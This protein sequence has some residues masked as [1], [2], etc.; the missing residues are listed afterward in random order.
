MSDESGVDIGENFILQHKIYTRGLK[1]S[2][3]NVNKYL[4]AGAMESSDSD[5]FVKYVQT[6]T[7]LLEG[8]HLVENK[9]VFPYFK[10]KLPEVPYDRLMD[11]HEVIKQALE[12]IRAAITHFKSGEDEIK[13]LKDIKYGL[14]QIDELWHPHIK[15]EESQLYSKITDLKLD[16]NETVRE[17]NEFS[18]FFQEHTS[19]PPYL[20][21]PF[22]VYNLSEEDRAIFTKS[23]PETVMKQMI[24]IDWKDKWAPMK[25]FLLK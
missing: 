25:Q 12:R 24:P 19:G 20:N 9:K 3:E 1:V 22:V 13:H 23:F 11:E 4:D 8:H 15:I 16:S 2:L 21:M 18:Q 10:D 7:S 14:E 17:M 5:G 6:L